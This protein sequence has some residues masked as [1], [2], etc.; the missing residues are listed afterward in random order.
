MTLKEKEIDNKKEEIR[1][2]LY[3]ED[4][5]FIEKHQKSE[6]LKV[7]NKM[8][9]QKDWLDDDPQMVRYKKE[10]DKGQEL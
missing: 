7:Y 8:T 3:G 1:C 4:L 6:S 10:E 5:A 9:A 2:L